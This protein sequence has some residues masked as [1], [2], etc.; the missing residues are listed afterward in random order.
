MHADTSRKTVRTALSARLAHCIGTATALLVLPVGIL[1]QTGPADAQAY[2]SRPI[3]W[4]VPFPAG[5]GADRLSRVIGQKLTEN[6]GQQTVIEFRP[7]AAGNIGT[8]FVARAAPDGYTIGLVSPNL[9]TYPSLYRKPAYD[10]VKDFAAVT[11][12]S[13]AS[14]VLVVHPSVPAKSVRELIALAKAAP[15]RLNYASSGVGAGAHLSAELFKSMAGVN[16]V[17]VPYKGHTPALVDL[18]AGQTDMMFSNA[19]SGLPHIQAGKL[20]ALAVTTPQRW[21][22][23]PQLPTLSESGL[24][25]FDVTQWSGLV[26]PAGT[27]QAIIDK[28]SGEVV[29]ILK[30]PDVHTQIVALGF[31]PVGNT[32]SEFSAHIKAEIAKWAKVIKAAGI[33]AD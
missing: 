18:I 4:V 25:G 20:K 11:L 23:L 10:P 1:A 19:G 14:F 30:M 8:E 27:P 5:G 7:G 2:P 21:A 15:G 13:T 24:P 6:W 33:R 22:L 31:T 9:A 16:I 3:R 26:A 17:H 29:R 12:V 32:P 28:L